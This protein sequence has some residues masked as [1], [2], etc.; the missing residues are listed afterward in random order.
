[1]KKRNRRMFLGLTLTLLFAFALPTYGADEVPK[2]S[3]EELK[4]I[5]ESPGLV[6]FDVRSGKDWGSSERKIS[7]AVRV[8]SQD[9]NSWAGAYSKEQ[10]MVFYCA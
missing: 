6:I 4:D 10:K 2:I 7:G 1:M 9:I 8:N 5:L 3:V